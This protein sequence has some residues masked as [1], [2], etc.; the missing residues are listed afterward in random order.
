[1]LYRLI[2]LIT[3]I[4]LLIGCNQYNQNEKSIVIIPDQKYTNTG[5]AL[6]YSDVLKK[7]KI[8]SKKLT[9]GLC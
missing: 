4:F 7:N 9:I 8:I 6:I 2:F 5:F 1:M 3:S